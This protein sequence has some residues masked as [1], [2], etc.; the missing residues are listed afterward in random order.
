MAHMTKVKCRNAECGREFDARAADVD[1]G[2]GTFCSKSC[3][4]RKQT[5]NTRGGAK[6]GRNMTYAPWVAAGVD[7]ETYLYYAKEYG[8]RPLFDKR[9]NYAGF[10]PDPF[11]NATDVQNSMPTER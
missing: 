7:K 4:A 8:G 9:G 3:K 11:D 2:W 6:S 1:R 10:M 5:R